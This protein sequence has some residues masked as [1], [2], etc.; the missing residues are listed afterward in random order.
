MN[1][2]VRAP[3]LS[4]CIPTWN[5]ASLL[6]LSLERLMEQIVYIHLDEVEILISD[7]C[8]S[9]NTKFVVQDFIEKGLPIRYIR[10]IENIGAARNFCRC[11]ECAYGK[12]IIL[13]GDDDLLKVGALHIILDNLRNKEYGLIFIYNLHKANGPVE[14]DNV[15]TFF[16]DISFWITFMS[17]CIFRREIIPKINEKQYLQTHLL[18]MPFYIESALSQNLNLILNVDILDDGLDSGNNGGFNLFEVFICN[19]LNIWKGY[20]ERKLLPRYLYDFLKKDIFI[21]FILSHVYEQLFWKYNIRKKTSIIQKNRKGYFV[22]N[23]YKI[24]FTNYS[25]K[26]YFYLIPAYIVYALFR[27]GKP[28]D[29]NHN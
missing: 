21:H 6:K 18:Q 29:I 27:Y 19:Y 3:L 8:S 7:N 9:D 14:Y 26:W 5:R 15:V 13:L 16:K 24:L 23:A 22:E 20:I 17:G 12:Y 28:R 1:G 25:C 11:M 10:N 2:I 4:I